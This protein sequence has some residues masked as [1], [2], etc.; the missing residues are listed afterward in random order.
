AIYE[1][2]LAASGL[3]SPVAIQSLM[4][5][6]IV[7][8]RASL[9]KGGMAAFEQIGYEFRGRSMRDIARAIGCIEPDPQTA[10]SAAIWDAPYSREGLENLLAS[11]AGQKLMSTMLQQDA[12]FREHLE[13]CT[14]GRTRAI[15]CDTG[16]FGSTHQLLDEAF[17]EK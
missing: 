3:S 10:G 17:P 16:L 13:S 14:K 4:I 6:R 12:L 11:A 9:L 7:A 8:V 1:K 5:S 15:L 2:F